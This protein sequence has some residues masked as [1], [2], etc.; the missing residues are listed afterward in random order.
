[1]S[2]GRSIARWEHEGV[3]ERLKQ[4]LRE[5][6]HIFRQRKSIVEHVFGTIKKIWG[7]DQLLLRGF[8]K[9]NAEVSLMFLAYNIKRVL[10]IVGTQALCSFISTAP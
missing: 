1:V 4:R 6:P 5:Q 8:R 7:Y 9:I 3:L 10:N 2:R